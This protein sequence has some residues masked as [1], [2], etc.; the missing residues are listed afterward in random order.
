MQ[1]NNTRTLKVSTLWAI[2][3]SVFMFPFMI[4]AVNIALPA[5]QTD[6][7]VDAVL[8]SWTATAYLLA[9][10]VIL[11][12]AGKLGDI[13]GRKKIFAAGIAIF[14]IFTMGTA[15][16]PSIYW[17][18]I[19]RILQGVGAAMSM[20]TSMAIISDVFPAKERGKAMRYSCGL[21]L[22]R[23]FVWSFCQWMVN[24]FAGMEKCISY[25]FSFRDVSIVSLRYKNQ[26]KVGKC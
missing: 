14:T 16:V 10:G 12:P 17:I 1:S 2:S 6:F 25:Q 8:L 20:A 3:L 22:Y 24:K 21:C 18:I 9:S 7:S 11:V 5:I 19:F 26:K 4:S 13:Y 23:I 15:F